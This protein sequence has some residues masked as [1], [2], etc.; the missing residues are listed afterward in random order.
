MYR[1]WIRFS[2]LFAAAILVV[3]AG[4]PLGTVRSSGPVKISGA[5]LRAAGVPFWPV[6]AGDEIATGRDSLALV[7]S[8]QLGRVEV[9]GDS[10]VTLAEDHVR[11][12]K[13]AVGSD[14]A[15]IQARDYT[16]EAK[17][18][19]GGPSWFVV[20][21]QK[22]KLV[23]A[24]HQ[25]DVLITRAGAAPLLVPAGSYALPGGPVPEKEKERDEEKKKKKRRGAGAATAGAATGATILGMS[26]TTA[27]VVGGA[28]AASAVTIAA[29]TGED[30]SPL[31][32]RTASGL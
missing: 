6:V 14:Q 26:A 20:A 22:G 3:Q 28:V 11:L 23:V 25:G 10:R 32:V 24:A 30:S 21:D 13:G 31:T 29:A 19:A 5:E 17:N 4:P 18:T 15:A 2:L 16:F 1:F 7:S 12:Q 27:A 8:P 9:R